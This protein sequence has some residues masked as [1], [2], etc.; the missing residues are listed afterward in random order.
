MDRVD[1]GHERRACG[2]ALV[3]PVEVREL[4][5]LRREVV[6]RRREAREVRALVADVVPTEVVGEDIHD[7]RRRRDSGD[8]AVFFAVVVASVVAIVSVVAA[9]VVVAVFILLSVVLA[10]G[11][12]RVLA[13]ALVASDRACA[14]CCL[15]ESCAACRIVSLTP[16][17]ANH[18][19][20][21]DE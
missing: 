8:T 5:A 3:E 1:A 21:A 18:E 6:E 19:C 9:V 15:R 13:L 17:G 12:H 10:F 20:D 14:C 11:F 7:V 2:R 16:E 4:D